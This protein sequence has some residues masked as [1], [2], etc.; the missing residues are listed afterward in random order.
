MSFHWREHSNITIDNLITTILTQL[1]ADGWTATDPGYDI[2]TSA[3]GKVDLGIDL[4][5][6][7]KRFLHFIVGEHGAWNTSTH[8]WVFPYFEYGHLLADMD[9]GFPVGTE[10]GIVKLSFDE[11]Y[12]WIIT[13]YSNNGVAYRRCCSFGGL[14]ETV[15]TSDEALTFGSSLL[16]GT[17]AI[18]ENTLMTAH[19][20]QIFR[21]ISGNFG[22]YEYAI[23]FVM[24]D[25][26]TGLL[27]GAPRL[28][29]L[30]AT[31]DKR[32]LPYIYLSSNAEIGE[33]A[34]IRALI[35]SVFVGGAYD[36]E[37]HGAI[38]RATDG[39]EYF[40]FQQNAD[41]IHCHFATRLLVRCV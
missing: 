5:D 9:D 10:L 41:Y 38:I 31:V 22:G 8:A 32:Y 2:V 30:S 33:A 1:I 34:G 11:S 19:H 29:L 26:V 36:S 16:M 21:N 23:T 37:P 39:K 7:D 6:P 12:A 20:T 28:I 4:E 27:D 17:N 18:P 14:A 40:Y 13:D 15:D 24:P 25:V 35:P 3:D